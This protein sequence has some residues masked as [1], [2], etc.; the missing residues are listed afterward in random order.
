MAE[1]WVRLKGGDNNAPV[2]PSSLSGGMVCLKD[3]PAAPQN[4][5]FDIR[6]VNQVGGRTLVDYDDELPLG[7]RVDG[8]SLD[9]GSE[10]SESG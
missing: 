6:L 5:N 2:S 8:R 9:E 10:E 4:V 1:R 7:G 3:S